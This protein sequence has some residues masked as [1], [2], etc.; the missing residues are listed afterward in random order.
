MHTHFIADL[1]GIFFK[2]NEAHEINV[3]TLMETN[4]LHSNT[5]PDTNTSISCFWLS[6]VHLI[7]FPTDLLWRRLVSI[8]VGT[9][10]SHFIDGKEG[11]ESQSVCWPKHDLVKLAWNV[12]KD[13]KKIFVCNQSVFYQWSNLG[14]LI[15]IW[16]SRLH[17]KI[18]VCLK[19]LFHVNQRKLLGKRS[20]IYWKNFLNFQQPLL[21]GNDSCNVDKYYFCT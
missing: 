12:S 11:K 10:I 19:G 20:A 3:P 2:L 16:P 6:Y 14:L 1:I 17:V 13:E 5:F 21:Q 18:D 15:A 9:L 8:I 7:F 4:F